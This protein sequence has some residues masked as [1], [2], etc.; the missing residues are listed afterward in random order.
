MK[1]PNQNKNSNKTCLSN[2]LAQSKIPQAICWEETL[3]QTAGVIVGTQL[4]PNDRVLPKAGELM[5][6]PPG[7][8]AD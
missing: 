2:K 8:A 3:K 5:L 1:Q 4:V 7:T 6:F